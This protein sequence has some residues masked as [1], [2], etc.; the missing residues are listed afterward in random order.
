MITVRTATYDDACSLAP[1][2]RAADRREIVALSGVTPLT[3]LVASLGRSAEARSILV[4][5]TVH[6]MYGHAPDPLGRAAMVWALGT[7]HLLKHRLVL[8]KEMKRYLDEVQSRYGRL[9]NVVDEENEDAI[10]LLRRLNFNFG[11][12]ILS[13]GGGRAMSFWR[14]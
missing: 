6:A 12:P 13:V 5:D 11:V 7:D 1:R 9:V 3:A 2:L 4:N 8:I 10:K 14:S